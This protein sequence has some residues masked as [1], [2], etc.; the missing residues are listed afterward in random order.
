MIANI[1]TNYNYNQPTINYE[2]MAERPPIR[3]QENEKVVF[4]A[5]V[6]RSLN[7]SIHQV[8]S[9]YNFA[10]GTQSNP[11]KHSVQVRIVYL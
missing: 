7:P 2:L 1:T 4:S 5:V 6:I 8:V 9:Q 11:I 10:W 3:G